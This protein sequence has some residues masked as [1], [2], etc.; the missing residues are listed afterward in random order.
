MQNNVTSPAPEWLNITQTAARCGIAVVTL[1]QIL[2]AAG[3]TGR[4]L[5]QRVLLHQPTVDAALNA[6]PAVPMI[7][8]GNQP[9]HL[10]GWTRN[11]RKQDAA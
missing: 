4:R 8:S 7:G 11:G 6:R 9:E 10:Y 3:V 2:N 1:K 5:G